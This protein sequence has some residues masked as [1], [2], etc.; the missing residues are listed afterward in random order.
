MIRECNGNTTIITTGLPLHIVEELKEVLYPFTNFAEADEENFADDIGSSDS[1]MQDQTDAT[2][3]YST[4]SVMSQKLSS[5]SLETQESNQHQSENEGN[6]HHYLLSLPQDIKFITRVQINQLR[7]YVNMRKLTIDKIRKHLRCRWNDVKILL[8]PSNTTNIDNTR[9]NDPSLNPGEHLKT[10]MGRPL[11]LPTELEIELV[12]RYKAEFDCGYQRTAEA[13]TR[14]GSPMT[15]HRAQVIFELEGLYQYERDYQEE[16]QHPN[17]FV[18]KYANQLWHTD[19]HYW[20]KVT[21]DGITKRT[22]VIAFIDDR[23][24]K[25]L[26]TEVLPDKSMKQTASALQN[27]LNNNR[28]PHMIVIDNGKEFIGEDFQRVLRDN[29]IQ[30]HRI[31][32]GVP[33]ENAKIERWWGTLERTIVD[34]SKLQSFVNEYNTAWSHRGLKRLAGKKMTPEE[35]WNTFEHYEGKEDLIIVYE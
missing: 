11:D 7:N 24:R 14:R 2:S 8:E 34:H 5:T 29:G 33:E 28:K 25:I 23:T 27:A 21:V 10:H 35:A 26:H 16:N 13:L 3:T 20:D 15:S 17:R 18:A 30:V 4:T 6:A 12:K 9:G 32:V 31:H 22:Y 1:S 19:L